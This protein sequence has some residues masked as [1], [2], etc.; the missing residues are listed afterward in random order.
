MNFRRKHTNR[1]SRD[2]LCKYLKKDGNAGE[3]R[4]ERFKASD[5]RRA[6]MHPVVRR[7]WC[8]MLRTQQED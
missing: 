7:S 3:R 8:G 4:N 6:L 2:M 1:Y 5:V